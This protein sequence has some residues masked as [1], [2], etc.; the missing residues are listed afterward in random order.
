MCQS[1][2]IATVLI[3]AQCHSGKHSKE[4]STFAVLKP[5]KTTLEVTQTYVAQIKAAQHVEIR[6]FEKGYLQGIYVDE[7][8]QI[9]KGKKMFQIMPLLNRSELEKQQAEFNASRIE[10]QNTQQLYSKSIVSKSELQLAK[11]RI[12]RARASL[13][14]AKAH[15]KLSTVIAPFSGL[16]DRFRVRMGSLVEEGEL[17][18]T[19][20]DTSKLWVYFNVSER[21]YLNYMK[22][23]DV[24]KSTSLVKLSL[25]N[26]QT[27]D[28]EGKIDAI[29]SDFDSDT[30]NVAFR[31]TFNNPKR[32][33]RHGETGNI[34]LTQKLENVLVIPQKA[35]YEVL[36]K[37]FVY[38]VDDNGAVA[39]KEITIDRE[40][41]HLFVIQSNLS[42]QDTILL[43]GL[44][45]VKNGQVIK[46]EHQE[47]AKVMKGLD[48]VS[49]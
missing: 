43:E 1:A 16:M 6:S 18:T 20:S 3:L 13:N 8:Q 30:G 27:Y 40:V 15:L 36:D 28:E 49:H 9:E 17:L 41:P 42:E 14:I 2:M 22:L 4:A 10:Y 31:A 7:G 37:K 5:W 11:A 47:I 19:L 39:S 45:R 44:G 38:V 29:E 46:F 23:K 12:D 25:A 21:D 34:L 24:S 26:G 48:L 35:T 32:L 33:L